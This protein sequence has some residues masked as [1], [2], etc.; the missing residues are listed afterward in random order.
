[1]LL[2]TA[3]PEEKDTE[4]AERQA[5]VTAAINYINTDI[6]NKLEGLDPT[7]QTEADD[8]V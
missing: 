5:S 7:Q 3:K 2:D 8:V 6:C 4:D 1:M